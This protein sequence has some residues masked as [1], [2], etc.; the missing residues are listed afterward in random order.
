[1]AIRLYRILQR[2][3]VELSEELKKNQQ[4]TIL[5]QPPLDPHQVGSSRIISSAGHCKKDDEALLYPLF[6]R[7]NQGQLEDDDSAE[8]LLLSEWCSQLTRHST[9]HRDEDDDETDWDDE[10]AYDVT[11][12]THIGTVQNAIRSA[13]R[14]DF[15]ADGPMASTAFKT[16]QHQW[17]IRATQ[18][19]AKQQ[20]LLQLSS[21]SLEQDVQITA[22]S[23]CIGRSRTEESETNYQFA[24]RIRIENVS[25]TETIQLLGRTWNIQEYDSQH[26][27]PVGD[28]IVV[29]APQTGA[30][31]RLPVL[32]PGQAFEYMS[33]SALATSL[34]SMKGSFHFAW[35][36]PNTPS[37]RVG[38]PVSA[39]M[40]S[41]DAFEVGIRPFWLR[42]DRT[43]STHS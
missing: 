13:F 6:Y 5:L 35:V 37:A 22:T 26:E 20:N 36:P 14:R 30:V 15:G 33:G 11:L 25:A 43:G 9:H 24:Y 39:L 21:T 38:M 19:L 7:W 23:T 32:Q 4:T 34:G 12:W 41:T 3:C 27:Q 16:L 28:P 8:E 42:H 17:A 31:G 10:D 18:M 40:T 1:M 29:H 2:Q